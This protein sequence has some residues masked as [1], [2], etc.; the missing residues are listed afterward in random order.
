MIIYKSFPAMALLVFLA[1]MMSAVGAA[2]SSD[3][4]EIRDLSSPPETLVVP[5]GT[6]VT[7]VNDDSYDHTVTSDDGTF[8]SG[9]LSPGEQF[10][11]L[12][13]QTGYYPYHCDAHPS[14]HGTI[15]VTSGSYKKTSSSASGS[16]PSAVSE[17]KGRGVES[18]YSQYDQAASKPNSASYT[19]APEK[20]EAC[21]MES[22]SSANTYGYDQKQSQPYSQYQG[23]AKQS[24]GNTLWIQGD[25]DWTQ[26]ATAP[27]GKRLSLMAVSTTED[28]GYLYETYPDGQK[29]KDE[30][31]FFPYTQLDFYADKIGKHLLSFSV[32]NQASNSVVVDVVDYN[33]PSDQ[34]ISYPQQNYQVQGYQQQSYQQKDYQQQNYQ[35]QDYKQ[36]DYSQQN[37]QQQSYQQN[38]YKQKGYKQQ[39]YQQKD[40]KQKDY[41]QQNYQQQNYQQQNYQQPQNYQQQSYQQQNYQQQN[42]QQQSYQQPQNYQQQSYQQPYYN[43]PISQ[44][45]PVSAAVYPPADYSSFWATSAVKLDSKGY[46][47]MEGIQGADYYLYPSNTN[48]LTRG[49][50]YNGVSYILIANPN[51]VPNTVVVNPQMG[52]WD[53]QNVQIMY[54]QPTLTKSTNL[55]QI[56]APA[57]QSAVII[58]KPQKKRYSFTA[59]PKP[60][61]SFRAGTKPAYSSTG[62]VRQP[63]SFNAGPKQPYSF[64]IGY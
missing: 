64:R 63:Y 38:N 27:L 15:Q 61:Y 9:R 17:D 34:K 1:C 31:H 41:N 20:C 35:Q 52:Y 57:Y 43:Q 22:G 32:N 47:T 6:T 51:G 49:L 33:T 21:E 59:G 13:D 40:Y 24:G 26:H 37:Y 58:I 62:G 44:P 60:A 54:G 45:K 42:Y 19:T 16:Y 56:T 3:R 25:K 30:H 8:H 48:V 53:M 29:V 10:S 5:A 4:I 7:W 14:V 36:N 46:L 55:L 50:Y 18:K 28:D 2:Q 12:F 39:K 11:H 23:S